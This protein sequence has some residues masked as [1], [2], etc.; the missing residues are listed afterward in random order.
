MFSN[1]SSVFV[2]IRAPLLKSK[3]TVMLFNV[4]IEEWKMYQM[5]V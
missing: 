2:V 1:I 4:I 5:Q 3:Y